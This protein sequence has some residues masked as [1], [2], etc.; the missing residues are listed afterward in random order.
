[1]AKSICMCCIKTTVC[2]ISNQQDN[3]N[4]FNQTSSTYNNT[5]QRYNHVHVRTHVH[6]CIRVYTIIRSAYTGSSGTLLNLHDH[7][8]ALVTTTLPCTSYYHHSATSYHHT[9]S[10]HHSALV[11]TTLLP[12]TTTFSITNTGESLLAKIR[13]KN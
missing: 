3:V 1:M 13:S 2:I 4:M 7:H 10:Y 8:S 5:R 12:A 11:T 6:T 9:L